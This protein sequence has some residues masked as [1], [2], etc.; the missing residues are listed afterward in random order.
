MALLIEIA[1]AR[2]EEVAKL[3]AFVASPLGKKVGGSLAL[4][5]VLHQGGLATSGFSYDPVHS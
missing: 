1:E 4:V 5:D 3:V 2:E